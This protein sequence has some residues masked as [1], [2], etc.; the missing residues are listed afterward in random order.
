M[1]LN[2]RVGPN[3]GINPHMGYRKWTLNRSP[4]YLSA[5]I[6]LRLAAYGIANSSYNSTQKLNVASSL[7]SSTTSP[8]IMETLHILIWKGRNAIAKYFMLPTAI[9]W[10]LMGFISL[11]WGFSLNNYFTNFIKIWRIQ[12]LFGPNGADL[13]KWVKKCVLYSQNVHLWLKK[14]TNAQFWKHLNATLTELHMNIL[15]LF[16]IKL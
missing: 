13:S 6:P 11:N 14:M 4:P 12:S 15:S 1:L 9:C 7:R 2:S 8:T 10:Y 16:C 3:D 5:H